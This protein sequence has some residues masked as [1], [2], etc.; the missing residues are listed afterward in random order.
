MFGISDYRHAH[1]SFSQ[2]MEK[3]D[4][5]SRS[6]D[7]CEYVYSHTGRVCGEP[8]VAQVLRGSSFCAIHACRACG[9]YVKQP[10]QKRCIKCIRARRPVP[11]EGHHKRKGDEARGGDAVDA[12]IPAK[13]QKGRATIED[14]DEATTETP[15]RI[16]TPSPPILLPRPASPVDRTPTAVAILTNVTPPPSP[17]R[18]VSTGTRHPASQPLAP[19]QEVGAAMRAPT[20]P[21][22]MGAP[23]FLIDDALRRALM[24]RHCHPS[25]IQV[26]IDRYGISTV[27]QIAWLRDHETAIWR[28]MPI[29]L[30]SILSDVYT[31]LSK[32]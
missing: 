22:R 20:A 1:S 9:K 19:P 29:V 28:E 18:P 32:Q 21:L 30:R 10:G 16:V 31:A 7:A 8:F 27:G 12:E 15:P 25:Q 13:R 2:R 5:A 23:Q 17:S 3:T 24:A 6:R 14:D 4:R 26:L 11:A